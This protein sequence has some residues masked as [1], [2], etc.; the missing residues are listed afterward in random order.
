MHGKEPA[1][2]TTDSKFAGG[3][4]SP[5]HILNGAVPTCSL[6]LKDRYEHLQKGH[7]HAHPPTSAHFLH[8]SNS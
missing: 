3:Q 2:A 6:L 4:F 8:V 1:L 7:G 5:M